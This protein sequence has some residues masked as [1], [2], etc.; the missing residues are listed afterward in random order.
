MTDEG[1]SFDEALAEAQRLGSRRPIPPPT[2]TASTPPTSC[3]CS[4]A[5]LRRARPLRDIP[6]EGIRRDRPAR[7][8]VRARARLHDQAAGDR[9]GRRHAIE[10]RVHPTMIPNA[11]LLADVRGAS[12]RLRARRRAR[13]DAL[14]RRG[15][16]HAADRHARC[17]PTSSR[18]PRPAGAAPSACRRSACPGATLRARARPP[19]SDASTAEY[20]LR[21]LV[22]RPP[23]RARPDRRILG[24][25]QISIASVIQKDRKR[26]DRARS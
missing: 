22:A 25:H 24:R 7:H 11:H 3:R 15:R 13:S 18:W 8:R 5:R 26:G 12:T 21:F 1:A 14:R 9:Q 16:R 23:G 4:H 6:T 17:S 10:A 20:Y 2:S 19:D